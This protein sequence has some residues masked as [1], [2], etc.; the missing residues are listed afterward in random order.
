MKLNGVYKIKTISRLKNSV[1]I[2][3]YK[4]EE[5]TRQDGYFIMSLAESS[6]HVLN[7]RTYLCFKENELIDVFV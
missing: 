3:L 6:K 1:E 4:Q 5:N 2:L 7:D